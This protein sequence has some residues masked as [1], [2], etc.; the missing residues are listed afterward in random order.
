MGGARRNTAYRACSAA[1]VVHVGR[2]HV[3]QVQREPRGHEQAG[4]QHR[5]R[6]RRQHGRRKTTHTAS[7]LAATKCPHSANSMPASH[8]TPP[9]WTKDSHGPTLPLPPMSDYGL[10]H[11]LGGEKEGACQNL[12]QESMPH[13]RKH[14]LPNMYNFK[15]SGPPPQVQVEHLEQ[16]HPLKAKDVEAHCRGAGCGAGGRGEWSLRPRVRAGG[17]ACIPVMGAE[18]TTAHT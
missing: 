12:K 16:P 2:K 5:A 6:L 13:P 18:E 9:Q 10:H 14:P 4:L 8:L 3:S 11:L 17:L 7:P 15:A 1:Q